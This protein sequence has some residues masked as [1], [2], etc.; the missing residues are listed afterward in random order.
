MNRK[1]SWESSTFV[2]ILV[3]NTKE[4]TTPL[5]SKHSVP[6]HTLWKERRRTR[7]LSWT[8]GGELSSLNAMSG[9]AT[10]ACVRAQSP[11]RVPVVSDSLRPGGLYPTRLLHPWDFPGKN[12]G[13]TNETVGKLTSPLLCLGFS[14]SNEEVVATAKIQW[15][16]Q[17][18]LS[19]SQVP[20]SARAGTR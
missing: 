15:K 12:T 5:P 4:Q 6:I 9:P 3:A 2:H 20:G 8:P 19:T 16:Q 13:A 7:Q 18:F 1:C 10:N 11:G 17:L 14:L